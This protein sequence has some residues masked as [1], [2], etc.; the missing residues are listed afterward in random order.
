[1]IQKVL[2]TIEKYSMLQKGDKVIVAV[3]GGPDSMSLLH[4][5]FTIK[6]KFG[7]TICAAHI[8][9]CLRGE[10]ADRDEEFTGNFCRANGID[11]YSKRIDINK[12]AEDEGVSLESAGREARY[13]FFEELKNKLN[14]QKIALA[15]NANDQAETVLM[16]I[17]RGTGAEGLE[18]IRPVRD[19]IFIRPL[20]KVS[21]DEIEEYCRDNNI[22]PRI[23]K[24][25]LETIYTRNKIRLEL[26][27]YLKKNFN[28]DVIGAINRLSEMVSA[29]NAYIEEE[30]LN[31]Y[32]TYCRYDGQKLIIVKE[33]FNQ[34]YAVITRIIRNALN[35]LTGSIYNLE[36]VHI[37][38]I[39]CLEKNQTG[40]TA[41]LPDGLRVENVYGDIQIY[42]STYL[43]ENFIDN[44]E[45]REYSVKTGEK[46][47]MD[48]FD[49]TVAAR[50]K[51]PDSDIDFKEKKYVK[52]F[53][54]DKIKGDITIRSRKNGDI[55]SPLGL[56]GT[57]K[58]KNIFIDMKI[59]RQYRDKIPLL[60]F[61]DN[62]AWIIGYQIS[63]KYKLDADTKKIL[64]I[65]VKGGRDI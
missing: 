48:F 8:N 31:K 61:G 22:Q 1:M 19:K 13:E 39:I 41:V 50:I 60:C 12:K 11:F 44:D 56:M 23:D 33:A 25:N 15:H 9:H 54:L 45:N 64:E 62:I 21:R 38:E 37:D 30:V 20:I 65:T 2:E 17:F 3:S 29:D 7:I 27:P 57:K 26:I 58:L 24:T 43:K 40:K 14:A 35:N 16:R 32:K 52:Y 36:R 4:I 49:I 51:N 10:E 34:K 18:G 5:L 53:D 47:Y 6:E 28:E 46:I 63:E 42:N 55:F 59:P